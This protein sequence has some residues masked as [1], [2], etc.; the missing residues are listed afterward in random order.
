MDTTKGIATVS[1]TEA[2]EFATSFTDTL[3]RDRAEG[4]FSGQEFYQAVLQLS[5]CARSRPS[6]I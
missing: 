6:S 2:Y 4:R 5:I 1:D 3:G